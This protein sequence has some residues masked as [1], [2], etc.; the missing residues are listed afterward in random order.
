MTDLYNS[1]SS[2]NSGAVTGAQLGRSTTNM[3]KSGAQ[4]IYNNIGKTL[5]GDDNE[6]SQAAPGP[7]SANPATRT[8]QETQV[9]PKRQGMLPQQQSPKGIDYGNLSAE[10]AVKLDLT[11]LNPDERQALQG[12]VKQLIAQHPENQATKPNARPKGKIAPRAGGQ[13]GGPGGFQS[14]QGVE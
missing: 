11:K 10:E 1:F 9:Q 14:P 7:A 3:I 2:G 8:T 13:S 4:T 6:P 12:R 5:G